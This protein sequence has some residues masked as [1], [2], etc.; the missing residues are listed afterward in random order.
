M[1]VGGGF[2]GAS[3]ARWLRRTDPGI[4]VTLVERDERF[5]S[6][7]FSNLVLGGL[8]AIESVTFGYEGVRRAGVDVVRDSAVAIDPAA[9]RVRLAGGR[10]LDYDR[11]ILSP[12]VQLIWGA[13]EG[14]DEAAAEIMPHAWLGGGQVPLLRRKL[15]AMKDGGLVVIAVP[16]NP[17]RCPAAPYE[18]ASLIGHYLKSAKPRAKLM[19]LDAKDSFPKQALFQ[20]AWQAL[21]P[22]I[23]E[24][25]SRSQ[26]GVVTEVDVRAGR[27][28][29]QF[30]DF[31]ADVANIIPPQRAGAIAGAI[32]LDE[33][34][35][36]CT[37]DPRSFESK[38][39]RGIHVIGDAIIGGAMPKSGFSANSQAK[40]CAGAVAALLRGRP[41]G[42]P[43]LLNTC[44][45]TVAPDYAISIGG[46]YRPGAEGLL[47]EVPGTAAMSPLGAGAALH[48]TEANSAQSWFAGITADM[49]G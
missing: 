10:T 41:V 42:D 13:I 15:E 44:Y 22:G 32:G 33:G 18:R 21:Y 36:Y 38:V 17:S 24:W 29:T 2:G 48:A 4:A 31:T 6:C 35:G 39:H 5:V 28:S 27:V 49:F 1:I 30:D 46:T 9:R 26:S 20:E 34:R 40:V 14:Y 16:D 43:V 19:I 23:V 8:R 3:A 12:G 47:I 25:V 45:S 11:L 7:P 37:V